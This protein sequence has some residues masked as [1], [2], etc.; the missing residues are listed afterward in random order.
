MTYT[1]RK[2]RVVLSNLRPGEK[3]SVEE[4]ARKSAEAVFVPGYWKPSDD[5]RVTLVY[6][7]ADGVATLTDDR[8][9][10]KPS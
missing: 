10:T 6:L 5:F 3:L 8:K 4:L 7:L 2:I 1:E 9:I